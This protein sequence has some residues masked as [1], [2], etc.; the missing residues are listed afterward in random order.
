[1]GVAGGSS[2]G[3]L[4]AF[5]RSIGE[6]TAVASAKRGVLGDFS[7]GGLFDEFE[8][9]LERFAGRAGILTVFTRGFSWLS[10]MALGTRSWKD[11]VSRL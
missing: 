8:E 4:P 9:P 11:D 6:L 10:D 2:K 3:D 7:D 1:M 5:D